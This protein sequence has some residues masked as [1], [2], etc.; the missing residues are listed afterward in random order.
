MT[1]DSAPT[2][3]NAADFA[4][5]GDFAVVADL[6]PMAVIAVDGHDAATFLRGQLSSD[7]LGLSAETCEYSSYNS[8]AGRVLANL[9]LYRAGPNA[10]DGYRALMAADSAAFVQ[11]RLSMFVLRSKVTVT[12]AS[13][14]LR[15]FGVGGPLAG[16]AVHAAFGSVPA[17]FAVAH[18][19]SVIVLG[20]HGPRY[21]VVAPAAEAGGMFAALA[22]HARPVPADIWHWL[23]IRAG[24]PVVT[25]ATRDKFVPQMINWDVLGGVNFQKGC[26]TGQEIIARTQYLGRLKERLFAFACPEAHVRPGDRLWS[27]AFGDQPCGTVVNAAPAPQGGCEL[28]AV[29]QLAAADSGDVHLSAL[30][31]PLLTRLTLPYPVPE[32][33]A[34]RPRVV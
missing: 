11:K 3:R 29:L 19:G 34:A 5:A 18:H 13:S 4:A 32:P 2:A 10:G 21:I 8:P 12:D 23:R 14:A 7:I 27:A 16:A 25:E 6:A 15:V 1:A 33:K 28:L 26:Y 31:G 24:V 9:L 17:P 20:V 22:S 30:D